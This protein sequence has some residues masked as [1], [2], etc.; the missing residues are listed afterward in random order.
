MAVYVRALLAL[1]ALISLGWTHE[2]RAEKRLEEIIFDDCDSAKERFSKLPPEG[3]TALFDFLARVITLNTQAPGVPEPFAQLPGQQRP[4]E[5]FIPGAGRGADPLAASLWQTMDAKR[6][7]R[8]KRCALEL[9]SLG[10]SAALAFLPRL[11]SI[12]SSENLSDEIAVG[13]EETAALVA[14][15]AHRAGSNPNNI[16]I[17]SVVPLL[18]TDRSLVARN[19]LHEYVGLTLPFVVKYLSMIDGTDGA[20]VISFLKEVDPDGSRAMRAFLDLL[21]TLPDE[22]QRRLARQIPLPPKAILSQFVPEVARFAADAAKSSAFM[23][24]LGKSCIDLEGL[25]IDPSIAATLVSRNTFDRLS[26]SEQRCLLKS[27]PGFSKRVL[28]MLESED[29]AQK[30]EA[31]ELIAGAPRSFSSEQRTVAWGRIRQDALLGDPL[32]QRAALKALVSSA[33]YRNVGISCIAELLAAH[34]ATTSPEKVATDRALAIDMLA[35]LPASKESARL[36][37]AAIRSLRDNAEGRGAVVFLSKHESAVPDLLKALSAK[38]P[39]TSAKVLEVFSLDG[40]ITKSAVQPL[41]E[42]LSDPERGRTAEAILVRSPATVL[43]P[44]VKKALPRSS[45]ELRVS[46][47]SLL[48]AS[49]SASRSESSELLSALT[50]EGCSRLD[51]REETVR[52]L[53]AR[54]DMDPQQRSRLVRN[55]S[56]CL[57]QLSEKTSRALA[58]ALPPEALVGAPNVSQAIRDG[59]VS[60]ELQEAFLGAALKSSAT[61]LELAPIAEAILLNGSRPAKLALLSS[62][63]LKPPF[64]SETIKSVH[65][66]IEQS[67][68]DDELR[69]AALRFLIAANDTTFDW[70]KFVRSAIDALGRSDSHAASLQDVIRSLPPSVVLEEVS[71]ALDLDNQEK[72]IGACRVGAIL[73]PQAIPIVSK[74]WSLREKRAPGIRYAAVLALLE[75]NPLTPDLQEQLKKLLVN[76][77]YPSALQERIPWRNTVAVVDL[78]ASSFGTLRTD[79]LEKLLAQR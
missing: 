22:Q 65:E 50:A 30:T 15:Q 35:D 23:P 61:S 41:I 18:I 28:L 76:R 72:A 36:I 48:Q 75:I 53:L 42:M 31:I 45:G 67:T 43:T 38:D 34:P 9:F 37:P 2:C 19:F 70:K 11:A 51:R 52:K 13:L 62:P 78:N 74:V 1:A 49:G 54:T 55:A 26:S 3:H 47:L 25:S 56:E 6:E 40:P 77:Y 44:A 21:V 63:R 29:P 71:P 60:D 8:G 58:S 24:L 33:E 57:T 20:R 64:T 46:L 59:K 79:H 5:A 68:N 12:Y 32:V 14:E 4:G 10:G 69:A 66:V 17:E 16:D 7:L 39:G 27:L 73:G